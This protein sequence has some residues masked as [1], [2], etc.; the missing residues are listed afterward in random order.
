M[1]SVQKERNADGSPAEILL[2]PSAAAPVYLAAAILDTAG[3]TVNTISGH[4]YCGEGIN[5]KPA[6]LARIE[7]LDKNK[8]LTT[9]TTDL[10]GSYSLVYKK[11]FQG[12]FQFSITAK[13]GQL[14]ETLRPELVKNH[15]EVDFWIK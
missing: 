9:V 14:K 11:G 15:S 5:Q 12:G 2:Y 1:S 13:C 7:L 8:V 10:G 3:Q 4:V 6:N